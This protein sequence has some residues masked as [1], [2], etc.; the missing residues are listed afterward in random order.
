MEDISSDKNT[1][2]QPKYRPNRMSA[3]SH[4]LIGIGVFVLSAS[5]F[6]ILGALGFG[7]SMRDLKNGIDIMAQ[8]A[9]RPIALKAFVFFSS[10]LPLIVSVVVVSYL[11]KANV[12]DYMLLHRPKLNQYLLLSFAFVF[13]GLP[14]LGP[15]LELNKMIDLSQWPRLNDWLKAQDTSNN[16]AYEAMIG[17]KNAASFLTS[18]L[19]MAFL[20]ALAEELFFRGFLMNVCNGIFKNMH[21]AII[22]TSLLFSVI[23]LQ[24]LK[25][26]PMFFLAL[27]FGYAVYWTGSIWTSIVAH[28]INNL[29]AVI[30]LYFITDGD[31]TKAVNESVSL[32]FVATVALSVFVVSVFYYNQKNS[33]YKVSNFYV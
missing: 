1:L 11:I 26:I 24:V 23:H 13:F 5:V 16:N 14:L 17:E 22:V 6:G 27:T 21:V 25:F 7:I 32:P 29:L 10:S 9:E 19:F 20:P 31:Y 3:F 28:F 15:L 2:S 12:K 8:F 4:L 33:P 18:V 30:Q